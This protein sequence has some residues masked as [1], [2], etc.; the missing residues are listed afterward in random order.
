MCNGNITI[1]QT[2]STLFASSCQGI[3][4]D[5]Q[6]PLIPYSACLA[7]FSCLGILKQSKQMFY[8]HFSTHLHAYTH[9]YVHLQR[10]SRMYT[11]IYTLIAVCVCVCL[12]YKVASV[13]FCLCFRLNLNRLECLSMDGFVGKRELRKG[14]RMRE[15]ERDRGRKKKKEEEGKQSSRAVEGE[16]EGK[17][18]SFSSGLAR[19]C[20]IVNL[21]KT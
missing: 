11:H 20:A 16:R 15:E 9:T 12:A 19:S 5:Y 4:F 8:R 14:S 6:L 18:T 13:S 1:S 3:K 17:G 21:I 10:H 2:Q 7:P